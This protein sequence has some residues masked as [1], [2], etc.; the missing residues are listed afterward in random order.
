L[1]LTLL[2]I[3][4]FDVPHMGHASFLRRCEVFADREHIMVGVNSDAFVERYKGESPVFTQGERMSLISELGYRV[5]V[6]DGPGRVL[7][8]DV[9]PDIIAIGTDWA[10]RDYHAQIDTPVEYFEEHSIAMLYIPY[11]PGIST[12][13]L[14]A[15]F[16]RA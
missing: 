9:G 7:I 16:L 14:K 2:T 4:S 10:K 6:N 8:D 11:T 5:R 15:R 1:S 12:T 3:G 13:D